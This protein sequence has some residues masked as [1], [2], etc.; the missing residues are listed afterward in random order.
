MKTRILYTAIMSCLALSAMAQVSFFG[1]DEPIYEVTPARSTGLS[2]IYVLYDTNG[3]GMQ[4]EA[5]TDARVTWYVFSDMGAAYPNPVYGVS[6]NG[7]TTRLPNVYPNM[8]YVIEEGTDITYVWVVNYADYYLQLHSI[9]PEAASDCG[10]AT[11]Q[12]NGKG[13]DIEYYTI[14]GVRQV[15]D[16]E[17]QLSYNTLSW[18]DEEMQWVQIDT[19]EVQSSLKGTIVVPVPLCNTTFR[20]RGDRFLE[21][22]DE[23]V[24][25]E[26]NDTYVTSAVDVHTT[27]VQEEREIDNERQTEGGGLGGSAPVTITFSSYCTDAVVHKE[28]QMAY[29]SEFSNLI[30]RLNQDETEQTFEEAGTYYWRFVGSNEDGSC[31]AYSE[32]YTVNIGVSELV[33]PN[34][35][36]PGTSEKANDVW[37]V[38][39]KSIVEFH[40]WIFNTWGNQIIE[41]TDP[42]QGWD[43]TYRGKLVKPGVYYYV[44]RAKGA[45]GKEYKLSGDINIIRFK[46]NPY[47]TGGTSGDGGVQTED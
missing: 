34:V 9:V 29:D 14:T 8:G 47:D 4:Y 31:E 26:S 30:L 35:F 2:K 37:K 5:S 11:M 20:L 17:L 22:W 36:S 10:T 41:L 46:N 39:Y 16:R 6:R 13:D 18:S 38:S 32:T 28:W 7:R 25:V 44:I 23:A 42:S 19:V 15:L 24:E 3:V 33:C 27:A 45:D 12:V 1:N 21:F 43:G 40:C